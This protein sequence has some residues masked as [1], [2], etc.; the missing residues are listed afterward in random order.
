MKREMR[1]GLLMMTMVAAAPTA[2]CH[3]ARD[4]RGASD[5][6]DGVSLNATR[7]G[8]RVDQHLSLSRRR[9]ELDAHRRRHF[10]VAGRRWEPGGVRR[11]RSHS[12]FRTAQQRHFR[13][14]RTGSVTPRALNWPRAIYPPLP[15]LITGVYLMSQPANRR[16]FLQATAGSSIGAWIAG[17]V[18]GQAEAPQDAGSDA[19]PDA[20]CRLL[21]RPSWCRRSIS[22]AT[23]RRTRAPCTRALRNGGLNLP[24]RSCTSS[25][26]TPLLGSP[27]A[28]Q[29]ANR[30]F[31]SLCIFNA[32]GL[33]DAYQYTFWPSTTD[34]RPL[35]GD[36]RLLSYVANI[37]NSFNFDVIFAHFPPRLT[38]F[39][40]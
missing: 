40:Y 9:K 33:E 20:G 11:E 5:A 16:R 28:K 36:L 31:H 15:S 4:E 14:N 6:S 21:R 32:Y 35:T 38:G 3:A 30:R 7:G 2:N 10:L 13:S 8:T 24:Q 18:S 22:P 37:A 1:L 12:V 29:S 27:A 19:I 39:D 23:S 17:G 26:H 25:S 34:P